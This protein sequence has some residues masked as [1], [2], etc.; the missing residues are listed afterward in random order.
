MAP[1]EQI[2]I[3]GFRGI[4]A[5]LSL[6]FTKGKTPTSMVI[7]GRNGTGKSSITDA[8][9]WFHTEKIEHLAREGAGPSSYPHQNA[10]DGETFIKVQFADDELG[11][12]CLNFDH[13]RITMPVAEGDI[14]KFRELAPHPCHIRFGDLTRF[15][16]LTKSEK[17]DALAELM[18]FTPQVEFQKALRRVLRKLSDEMENRQDSV[19]RLESDLSNLLGLST[20]DGA[21]VLDNLNEILKQHGIEVASSIENLKT[22]TKELT[23]LVEEDPRSKKLADLGIL[24]GAIERAT[25]PDELGNNLSSYVT[26]AE[27]FEQEEQAT[28]DLL[29]IGLYR[30]G[31][32]VL[33]RL[34]EQ[35][36][37]IEYCPLCGQRFEGDLLG[38]ISGAL[39]NL[40][41]LKRLRDEVER[42]RKRVQ[43][44]LAPLSDLSRLLRKRCQ[45]IWPV[46]EKWGINS[47][48]EQAEKVGEVSDAIEI[49]LEVQPRNLD[50]EK[51]SDMRAAL[52]P[53]ELQVQQFGKLR[54]EL[55]SQV[56]S[57]IEKLQED[58]S[59]T[60]LVDDHANMR[61][62]LKLWK[63]LESARKQL[64]GLSEVYR[65]FEAVVED[66]VQSS[67]DNVQRRF[68]V[69]SSDVQAYF[70]ILEQHTEDI[71]QPVLKLLQDKD[72]A[73]V[74]EVEFRGEPIYPAYRYLSESQLN[75]FGLAV[76][77]AS[78]KYFNQDFKFLVL[79]DVINSFD[80]YKRPQVINLL[81]EEFSDHQVLLLTHDR[82]WR[83]RLFEACPNWVKRRFIR[84][85]PGVGPV[86]VEGAA[87]LDVI[88][89]YIDND[90]P[91]TAGQKMGP[92]LERQLQHL[93][94]AFGVMV[95]YNQRNQYTLSSL[96]VRFR[97]RV[98]KKLGKD[99]KLTKAIEALQNESGFRNLC[100][101]W[102]NP[103]IQI[104]PEE[105]EI[106]VERWQAIEEIVRCPSCHG[107]LRYDG[108]GFS[109]PTPTCTTCLEKS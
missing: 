70:E 101:H 1:I 74:L 51:I 20:V 88:Q 55:L 105:M 36:D 54:R 82:V 14:E 71:E 62:A 87:P 12:I 31:K 56:E 96:L 67:I 72:R 65:G 18:G 89:Q 29:L 42:K 81:K 27:A 22:K 86:D 64:A 23:A 7:Y 61:S 91:V 43:K 25:L 99:H 34:K 17:Y 98:K 93:C 30:Q 4:L 37:E 44:L 53:F 13:S 11:N 68:E 90:E 57:R 59:R 35:G 33:T 79:D 78:A 63:E 85:E 102:K 80:A 28:T 21:S 6:D 84:L 16:Y 76:F 92:F 103:A 19:A 10:K 58:A 9:E 104:T 49:C 97:V 106:V 66:Y 32:D 5:P 73:V 69:I 26:S 75:S 100:A 2:T 41:D 3:R 8:W 40:K 109:C 38:H 60:Q 83:D 95:K 48:V 107:H 50:T 15:V 77:L 45:E 47:F 52:N 39:S 46:A 24:K 108:K 94:E